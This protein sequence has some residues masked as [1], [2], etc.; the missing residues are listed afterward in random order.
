M[1][2]WY[3]ALAI[4]FEVLATFALKESEGFTY[5]TSSV[6]CIFGYAVAFFF[7]L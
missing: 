3:L 4:C 1:G 6:V 2:Y 5:P 7:C